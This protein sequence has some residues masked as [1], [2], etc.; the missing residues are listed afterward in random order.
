MTHKKQYQT[1]AYKAGFASLLQGQ[2]DH[3]TVNLSPSLADRQDW[4]H[5]WKEFMRGWKAAQKNGRIV[6]D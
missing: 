1:D 6:R 2:S 4:F 3:G 5:S